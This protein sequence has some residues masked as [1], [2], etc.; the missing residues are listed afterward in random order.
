MFVGAKLKLPQSWPTL[1]DPV[2]CSL[3]GSSFH[4]ILQARILE[5]IA[6]LQGIFSTQ[7]SNPH[8]LRLLHWQEG[9]LPMAPPGKPLHMA[10]LTNVKFYRIN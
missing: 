9:P 5:W 1:C 10:H 6:L 3:P 2:D 7:K 4:G 8:L